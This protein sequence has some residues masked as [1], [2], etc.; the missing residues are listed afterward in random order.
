MEHFQ[1]ISVEAS[2][3]VGADK[4]KSEAIADELADVLSYVLALA[5]ELDIDLSEAFRRKMEKNVRKYPADEIRGR[6][7][8]DDPGPASTSND[9]PSD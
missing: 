4:E 1:W 6:Y 7:G 8:H 2:R 3:R 5:N 9:E